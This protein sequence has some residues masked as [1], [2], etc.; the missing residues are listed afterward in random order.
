[1]HSLAK[2]PRQFHNSVAVR[3]RTRPSYQ[4]N[5]RCLSH[6]QFCRRHFITRHCTAAF[7]MQDLQ[8]NYMSSL[9]NHKCT[10]ESI[11]P[12]C[13]TFSTAIEEEETTPSPSILTP[14]NI[15]ILTLLSP[16]AMMS[17]KS[18]PE[19]KTV[20]N[21]IDGTPNNNNGIS[22]GEANR[23]IKQAQENV[24]RS[25]DIFQALP[26][27]YS[28]TH[29]L[30]AS[31]SSR[32]GQYENAIAAIVRYQHSSKQ[33]NPTTLQFVK[34]K[35]LLYAG[36]FN[37]ALAEYEDILEYME[38]E[39]ERHVA[40]P[41]ND[42]NGE[43]L[44]VIDGAA[45]LT[46]VGLSKFLIHHTRQ[47]NQDDGN[48]T[49]TREIIES[50]QTATE[51]LLETRKDA[52][53]SPKYGDLALNL[54]LAAVI[55]LTNFGI[56]QLLVSKKRESSIRRWR[57]GLEVLDQILHDSVN[58]ATVIPNHK[59][60][61]IQSLRARLYSNIACVL[62]QL[63]GNL[64]DSSELGEISEATLKE[65]SDM[66]KKSLHIYD[67]ILNGPNQPSSND[68]V[69]T[70]DDDEANSEEWNEMLK[71]AEADFLNEEN[72]D[73][74]SSV[75]HDLTLPPLWTDYHR[76]ES[77]RALGLVAMCY[78]HA[79]AAVTSEGLLQSALD[80]SSSY[81][82]GQCLKSEG[83]EVA[84]KGVP[85][86]SPNLALVARDVRLEYALL[87]DKWDK[88]KGD[89]DKFRLDAL[90]IER[91]GALKH[92]SAVSGL[93]SSLWLFSPLDFK[94]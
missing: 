15:P 84:A 55:S 37:H 48:K 59:Y 6:I 3:L 56:V 82:F 9:L 86:S 92:F 64:R 39:V 63:D 25:R 57:Q 36:K 27:L 68:A 76:A 34:A 91:D 44:P 61:C 73:S 10:S 21:I 24:Q 72:N 47:D 54:G 20:L 8:K 90:R 53:M 11:S 18:L 75:T 71:N 31:L 58:S 38:G 51:M 74:S 49:E 2:L 32:I 13:N 88:R 4:P 7:T 42:K 40:M 94:P 14:S 66:A 1:M 77:A 33:G 80:A 69:D 89:A 83:N 87:C 60:Q 78:Y 43:T 19:T 45:A 93:V 22:Q 30:E 85:L 28:A 26:E 12:Q 70:E 79:G 46:G 67:E 62:L 35:L 5:T 29:L 16:T 52:L 41:Q 17:F 65:A 50:I 81:P 23:L